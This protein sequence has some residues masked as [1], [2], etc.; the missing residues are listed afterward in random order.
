MHKFLSIISV[1]CNQTIRHGKDSNPR[2]VLA[3]HSLKAIEALRPTVQLL[4]HGPVYNNHSIDHDSE[5]AAVLA[6]AL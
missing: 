2:K 6:S 4:D 1:K 5:T 3:G